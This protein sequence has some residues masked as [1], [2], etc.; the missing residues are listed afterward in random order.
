M[1]LIQGG[2]CCSSRISFRRHRL[3]QRCARFSSAQTTPPFLRPGTRSLLLRKRPTNTKRD[4]LIVHAFLRRKRRRRSCGKVFILCPFWV[5]FLPL[6][7]LLFFFVVHA[8]RSK[9]RRRSCVLAECVN[10]TI[11]SFI[12]FLFLLI[13]LFYPA[14]HGAPLFLYLLIPR[15]DRVCQSKSIKPTWRPW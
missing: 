13:Y 2:R 9:R 3:H 12:L 1:L 11:Y 7:P 14:S 6:F 10:L 5:L 15:A 8:F 4:I